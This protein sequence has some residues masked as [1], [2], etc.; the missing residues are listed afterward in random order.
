MNL[1]NFRKVLDYVK[2][3]PTEW[4]Q[5]FWNLESAQDADCGTAYCI[6]G[7]AQRMAGGTDTMQTCED[8]SRF[9]ELDKRDWLD[10]CCWLFGS[11]RTLEEFEQVAAGLRDENGQLTTIDPIEEE[12]INTFIEELELK[13][14]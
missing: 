6:A 9:L 1:D 5:R 7:H 13:G 4:N 10:G 12:A 3:H 2:S 11:E 8:A 14:I